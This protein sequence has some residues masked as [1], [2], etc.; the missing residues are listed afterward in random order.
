MRIHKRST[1]KRF[2]STFAG[3]GQT[4]FRKIMA[5]LYGQDA[6]IADIESDF[7]IDYDTVSPDVNWCCSDH[8]CVDVYKA[9]LRAAFEKYANESKERDLQSGGRGRYASTS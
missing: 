3:I 2:S 4:G 5:F 8:I 1:N 7:G 9:E 6:I